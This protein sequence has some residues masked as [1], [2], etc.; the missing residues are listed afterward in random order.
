MKRLVLKDGTEYQVADNSNI[1]NICIPV[2]SFAAVDE[3]QTDFTKAN[4]TEVQMGEEVFYQVN[5]VSISVNKHGNEIL[6]VVYCQDSLEDY[7]QNQIDNYTERL[8][9]EGVI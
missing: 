5:P 1:S 2:E 7:I 4:M 8:I 6:C 3:L 9:E